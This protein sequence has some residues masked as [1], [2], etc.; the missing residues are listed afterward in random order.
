MHTVREI[1]LNNM[2]LANVDIHILCYGHWPN[3]RAQYTN[4]LDKIK[5]QRQFSLLNYD[6]SNMLNSQQN[7]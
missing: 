1:S 7:Y 6:Y 3:A 4:N 2:F 5:R